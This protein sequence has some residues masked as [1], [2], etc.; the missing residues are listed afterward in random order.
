MQHISELKQEVGEKN[1]G[2]KKGEGRRRQQEI[3]GE[4]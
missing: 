1:D 4:R 2:D 3:P